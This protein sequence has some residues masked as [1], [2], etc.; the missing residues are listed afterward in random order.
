MAA[1]T[2]SALIAKSFKVLKKH[3]KPV[4]PPRDRSVLEH[5]LFACCLENAHY[6]PANYALEKVYEVSYD[7]NEVRVTT[8]QELAESMP[9]LPEA[10]RSASN[11]K[12]VLRSIFESEYSYDLEHL[13]KQNIGKTTKELAKHDG[14]TPFVIAYVTQHA[15]G[16]HAIPLDRGAIDVMYIT[17]IIDEKE[18]DK[19]VVPGLERAVPKNK[20][21]EYASL[22]HQL[23][24]D[25]VASP[26]S[27]NVR[28]ILLEINP[29]AKDRLPKRLSRKK[30]ASPPKKKSEPKSPPTTAKK[31]PAKRKAVKPSSEK[32]T[33][34]AKPKGKTKSDPKAAKKKSKSKKPSK[35]LKKRKP[36]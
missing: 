2:R 23:A 26:F 14:T 6:D 27:P 30:K 22:L 5:M 12:R 15:L 21:I 18:K 24:A 36:R 20:G 31:T 7:W 33:T 35:T 32:K 1:T 17:G 4:P 34:K 29:E 10:R 25:L 9:G 8:A 3:Y 28:N 13:K 11:L 16:G 19:G